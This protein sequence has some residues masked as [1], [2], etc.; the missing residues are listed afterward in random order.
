MT[1]ISGQ[2]MVDIDKYQNNFLLNQKGKASKK[3]NILQSG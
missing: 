3:E 1:N 2:I